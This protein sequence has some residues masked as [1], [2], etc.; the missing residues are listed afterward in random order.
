[1][2]Y[3]D[4][5][6]ARLYKKAWAARKYGTSPR[7]RDPEKLRRM[8]SR[9]PAKIRAKNR[10]Q[11][12]KNRARRLAEQK[13]W[14]DKNPEHSRQWFDSHP[15]YGKAWRDAHLETV[16]A[17]QIRS[18]KAHPETGAAWR[19]AHPGWWKGSDARRRALKKDLLVNDLTHAQWLEIQAAQDHRCYYC[20]KRRKGHLTQD[21]ITPLSKGGDNTL[22]N[23]IAAC[24][25]CNSR[26]GTRKPPIPVQPFLLMVAPAKKPKKVA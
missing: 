26:K 18:N 14:R 3:K 8:P 20:G 7:K 22:H 24:G 25:S 5:E 1:M 17:G 19:K 23:V 6:K 21:H 12:L 11:Y 16:R 9:A 13:A 15:G 2:A 4:P 10:R